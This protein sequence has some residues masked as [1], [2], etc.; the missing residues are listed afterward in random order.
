MRRFLL[1]WIIAGCLGL[2]C[3]APLNA[4]GPVPQQPAP[5]EKKAEPPKAEEKKFERDGSAQVVHYTL[6]GIGVMVVMILVCMPAR[7]E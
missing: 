1:A 7:R 3:I 6:A 4:Q 2:A 5:E